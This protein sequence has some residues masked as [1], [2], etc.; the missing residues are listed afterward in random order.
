MVGSMAIAVDRVQAVAAAQGVTA[1]EATAREVRDALLASAALL[2]GYGEAPSVRAAVRGRLSRTRLRELAAKN[3]SEPG[4][5]E[6]EEATARHFVEL[7]R[8]EAFR[9]IHA[10]VRVPEGAAPSIRSRARALAERIGERVAKASTADDFRREAE[11]V[12]DR[13]DL[14]LVVEVLK[15][16]ASDGRVVDP[17]HTTSPADRYAIPFARAASRLSEPG[18]KSGV[19]ATE[20][21]FHVLMLLDKTPAH[22]VP[23]EERRIALR[24]EI[25]RDRANRARNELVAE[26]R[27]A[28]PPTVERSAAV[29]LGTLD[30][31][32]IEDEAR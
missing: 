26:L 9:V 18:Q 10:V 15:P 4:D 24:A 30:L 27:A 21:G 22:F 14:E 1:S 29:L 13:G 31:D 5:D 2:R 7:E 23:L 6:V 16:V 32:A 12:D 19:V 8:P 20:F 17:E 3:Q 11:S 28:F 25:M